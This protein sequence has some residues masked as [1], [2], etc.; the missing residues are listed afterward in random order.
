ML[1]KDR[2]GSRELVPPSR[3]RADAATQ[4]MK[5]KQSRPNRPIK[6]KKKKGLVSRIF[7]EAFDIIEDILD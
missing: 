3:I 4:P 5:V 2:S 7:E 6:R 1:P